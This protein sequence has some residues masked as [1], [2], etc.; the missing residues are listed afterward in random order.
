L[1]TLPEIRHYFTPDG[2]EHVRFASRLLGTGVA[3]SDALESLVIA[4]FVRG[5]SVRD[6][7]ASLAN[8]LGAGGPV[9]VDRV[10][11]VPGHR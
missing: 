4:G 1:R 8:A 5:L 9:E 2:L 11:R 3:R 7:E 10:S 6:V